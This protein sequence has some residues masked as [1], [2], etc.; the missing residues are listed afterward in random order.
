MFSDSLPVGA[1]EFAATFTARPQISHVIFDMDGTLSWMRHGWPQLMFEVFRPHFPVA[2]GETESAVHDLLVSEI[3]SL[4]GKQSIYQMIAFCEQ[5]RKRGGTCPE[6]EELLHEYQS[7]LDCV[8]A[9]R[10]QKLLRGETQPDE[11]VVFGA[12]AL[13]ERLKE[14]GLTLIILSGTIEHRVQEEANLL[15]LARYFGKHIYGGTPDPSLFSKKLVIDRLL[16]EEAISGNQLLSF[17]DGPVEIAETKTVGGLA[18]A[19]ASDEEQNGSGV[20]DKWKRK[21]LLKAGADAV[22]AD[23]RQPDEWL[24]RIFGN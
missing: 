17:G 5:V 4:N 15:D 16:R 18:V 14:R 22:M 2:P 7:R 21:Q 23:Y 20:M 11:F 13:L 24:R 3:L 6:A 8:I 10:S 12:R 19:V 9:E 1:I